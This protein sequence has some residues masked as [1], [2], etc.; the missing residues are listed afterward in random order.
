MVEV[1]AENGLAIAG[2]ILFRVGLAGGCAQFRKLLGVNLPVAHNLK[3]SNQSLRALFNLNMNRQ[4]IQGAVIVVID[5]RLDLRLTKSVGDVQG[6][7]SGNVA[8]E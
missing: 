1:I 5:F 7:Q 3:S 2:E 6:L 8:L 4:M